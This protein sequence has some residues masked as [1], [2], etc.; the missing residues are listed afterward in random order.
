MKKFIA[1]LAVAA[2]VLVA[3]V[4]SAQVVGGAV[5]GKV[6][7]HYN[8]ITSKQMDTSMRYRRE[9]FPTM[10][11]MH[12]SSNSSAAAARATNREDIIMAA[13]A[14]GTRYVWTSTMGQMR[15]PARIG[16][17][18]R[19]VSSDGNQAP[20]CDHFDVF[21]EDVAGN[22]WKERVQGPTSSTYCTGGPGTHPV[23]RACAVTS[24]V[25]YIRVTRID[26]GA[27]GCSAGGATDQ[28]IVYLSSWVGLERPV[29]SSSPT[30]TTDD[31]DTSVVNVCRN[32]DNDTSA[33]GMCIAGTAFRVIGRNYNVINLF[34]WEGSPCLTFGGSGCTGLYAVGDS[35][36]IMYR[37]PGSQ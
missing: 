37:A 8:G 23:G 11:S 3:G 33:D 17:T 9:L 25:A 6:R 4:A 14:N 32:D 19:E 24:S 28:V 22:V 35:F 29:N 7:G 12:W 21:G 5:V 34:T 30:L 27:G 18:W 1:G 2:S 20:G 13:A 10:E 15:Y 16:F 36:S 26:T 31:A